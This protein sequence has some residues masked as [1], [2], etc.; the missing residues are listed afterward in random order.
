MKLSKLYC[1]DAG[2]KN[3]R[4]NLRGLSVIYAD[5]IADDAPTKNKEK[6]N[7][8]SLGKTKLAELIDFLFLKGV[9]RQHFLFKEKN[10]ELIFKDHTFYLELLLNS[11][12]Y[13]TIRRSVAAPTKISFA[14]LDQSTEGFIPPVEWQQEDISFQPAKRLLADY[15]ALDFFSNKK[16]DYRKAISY[17]I[18]MQGDYED[19][20][21]LSKFKQGNDVDWKP[22]MFDLLGFDGRLLEAKYKNDDKR[23]DIKAFIE[24][25]K[26]EYSVKVEDRDD[27]VAQMQQIE[28]ESKE[29]EARIDSFNFYEQD[30]RLID[31]G[32]E[33]IESQ[34]SDLN[35]LSYG[36]NYEISRLQQS[37]QNKF[38]FNLDKVNKVFE[39]SSVYFPDQLRADYDALM[40]FNTALTTERNKLLKTTL[41]N[42]QQELGALNKQLQELNGRKENLLSFLRDTDSFKRFKQY[43]KD[44]VKIQGRLL[45]LEKRLS[46]IDL[47][48][49]KEQER[50]DLLKDIES[51]VL[52]LRKEFQHTEKNARYAD[53]R[54]R[55]ASYYKRI[56]D[57]DARMSWSVNNSNNVDFPP[58]KVQD[59]ADLEQDTA[60]DDGR[61]YKK[62]L[63][64]AFDLAVL[65]A[66]NEESY[67]RFVYHDDVLSQQDNGIKTR[68]IQLV[69]EL[70]AQYDFQYILSAIRSDLP[71]DSKDRPV[72]F[73]DEETVL[74][75]DKDE[76]GTLFGFEF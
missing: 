4:F 45:T 40:Q 69:R 36:L 2:F 39:E 23:N 64:I 17:S 24:N 1:N 47:I 43:Q 42:K 15:L 72:Y 61:T 53:I 66:Y 51:T 37:I 7:S 20:Y 54:A 12:R 19:V 5:V 30:K 13:L 31:E 34:I 21:K 11:G 8:H 26:N 55:F 52:Q 22:F 29:I 6:K 25:L 73:S 75:L 33:E 16:Y 71:V 35:T 59:K 76:A 57:E 74:R 63:C 41:D 3:V 67:F 14:L 44:L 65:C 28:A 56:M 18:R 62:M 38:A 46:T 70:S 58:P 50:E 68:L 48:L 10:G 32:I 49:A 9:N 27:I 60:K